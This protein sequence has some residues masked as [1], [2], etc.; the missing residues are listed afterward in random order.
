MKLLGI[1]FFGCLALP[2]SAQT[3]YLTPAEALKLIF[4]KS[5]QVLPERQSLNPVQQKGIEKKIGFRLEKTEWNF[6][7][8]KTKG[9]VDGYALI[10]QEVGK[11][12]PITFL[13]AIT[14]EGRV[15]EVEVLVYREPIGGEVREER[16]LRQYRG[17]G[18][19]DPVRVGRDLANVTG[20]TLSARAV[21]AGVKRALLLWEVF[22]GR[23]NNPNKN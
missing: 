2:L 5:E 19:S 13:T 23:L 4:F 9:K 12:E 16:F 8:A 18:P 22:Y 15:K 10:D 3:V 11:T 6:Y 21:S 1:I 20:A 14:P 7:V 17:K